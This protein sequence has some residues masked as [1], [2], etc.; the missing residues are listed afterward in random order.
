MDI[1][2]CL[3]CFTTTLVK[4]KGVSIYVEECHG[5]FPFVLV[6]GLASA[7]V[8]VEVEL[9]PNI[10]IEVG[11]GVIG[12]LS[13]GFDAEKQIIRKLD[14]N[15]DAIHGIFIDPGSGISFFVRPFARVIEERVIGFFLPDI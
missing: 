9:G 12:H 11:F 7:H 5:D 8:E 15:S 14:L 10:P 1:L 2:A 3:S 4:L 13:R 6:V